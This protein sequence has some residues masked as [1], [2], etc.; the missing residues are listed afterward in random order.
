MDKANIM[1]MDQELFEELKQHQQE[2]KEI[3]TNKLKKAKKQQMKNTK[4][5]FCLGFCIQIWVFVGLFLAIS[6]FWYYLW[7]KFKLND[8][9][10]SL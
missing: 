7:G 8:Y 1:K 4:P 3:Y 9:K 10:Y 2:L 6:S 5:S